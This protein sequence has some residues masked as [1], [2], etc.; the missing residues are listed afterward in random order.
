MFSAIEIIAER[1]ISQAIAEGTLDGGSCKGKPLVFED[2]SHIPADL[3]MAYKILKNAG[4]LPPE[5]ATSREI[6]QLEDLIAA[7]EDEHTRLRQMK[8][9]KVLNLKLGM[10]RQRPLQL[11][12]AEY[13]R[14]VT[15]KISL[16][17][18][19]N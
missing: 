6:R 1:R 17:A 19:K 10:M 16:A 3:R 12:D 9:L 7:G 11:E 5:L 15:E 8:K 4:Y 18:G 14:K 13:R 2:H